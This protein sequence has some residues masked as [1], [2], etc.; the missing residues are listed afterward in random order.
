MGKHIGGGRHGGT[1]GKGAGLLTYCFPFVPLC[2]RAFVP[3]SL[4]NAPGSFPDRPGTPPRRPLSPSGGE[5]RAILSAHPDD[6]DALHWLGVL[7]LQANRPPE[8]VPLLE[9]AA[10]ARPT[11][12]AFSHNLAQGYLAVRRIED[13]VKAFDRTIAIDPQPKVL[14]SAALAHLSLQTPQSAARAVELF[15][16]A[17]D[18]GLDLPELH[19]HLGVALLLADRTDEALEELQTAVR[20]L[21]ESA[22]PHLH[23]AA[24]WAQGAESSGTG[25]S[26]AALEINPTYAHAAYV[27]A[28]MEAE[29]NRLP[30]AEALLRATIS[31]KPDSMPAY[32]ALAQVL[33]QSGLEREAQEAHQTAVA[34][35]Q[36]KSA[37]SQPATT[38]ESIAALEARLARSPDAQK[39]HVLLSVKTNVAPPTQLPPG[40]ISG[41][42][43]RYAEQFDQH[44][45]EKLDYHVPEMIVAA[46]AGAERP[47]FLDILDLGCGTGLCGPLLRPMAKTL[48]GVDASPEMTR[49]ARAARIRPF[50][51]RRYC[52]SLEEIAGRI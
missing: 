37:P 46:V 3:Y 15:Q 18:A 30:E 21:P 50:G 34:L 29:D 48:V 42:F 1:K 28:V 12:S 36:G 22:E 2:V 11:D 31:M 27:L 4:S 40:S 7:I 16:K 38:S 41:L 49:K 8:A 6:P 19:Q 25:M 33:H 47:E 20:E 5:Y 51:N 9:R 35:S 52:R 44:L 10:A 14:Y 24:A 23:F 45:V 17:R 13:A 32:H 43:D 26:G 39:L